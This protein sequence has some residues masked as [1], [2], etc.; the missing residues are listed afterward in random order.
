MI[1]NASKKTIAWNW[2]YKAC[3]AYTGADAKRRQVLFLGWSNLTI[4]PYR[5]KSD[6]NICEV[7]IWSNVC[8]LI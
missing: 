3:P 4:D 2:S 7:K 6:L 1:K 5:S 8:I